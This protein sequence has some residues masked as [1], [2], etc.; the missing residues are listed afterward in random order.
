MYKLFGLGNIPTLNVFYVQR[1]S[2]S[3]YKSMLL[4]VELKL[5]RSRE[6]CSIVGLHACLLG[7]M[8]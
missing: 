1:L 6:A 2:F 4:K 8:S 7:R 3:H 5:I